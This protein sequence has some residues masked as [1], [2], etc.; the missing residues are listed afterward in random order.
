MNK[1]SSP[2]SVFMLYFESVI[3]LLVKGTNRYYHQCWTR[4]DRIPNPLPDIMNSYMFPL[5]AI[6]QMGHNIHDRLTD[7][8]TMAEQF[9]TPFYPNTMT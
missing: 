1:D 8:W 6:I 5:L 2:L 7:N 4:C 3:D 9:F